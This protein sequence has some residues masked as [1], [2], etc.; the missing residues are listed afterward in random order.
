MPGPTAL[1]LTDLTHPAIDW[2]SLASPS[3][4]I[5]PL[6]FI[7]KTLPNSDAGVLFP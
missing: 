6:D 5:T 2:A 7:R 4:L 1:A 3:P